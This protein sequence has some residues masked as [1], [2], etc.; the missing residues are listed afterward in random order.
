MKLPKNFQDES[1]SINDVLMPIG[2][3]NYNVYFYGNENKKKKI[4]LL[5]IWTNRSLA[6]KIALHEV[7]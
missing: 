5:K 7:S 1:Y 4:Y 2:N 6:S 3:V